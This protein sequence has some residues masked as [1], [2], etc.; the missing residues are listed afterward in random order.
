MFQHTHPL[1]PA[2]DFDAT[3]ILTTLSCEAPATES[4]PA[5][6]AVTT[7]SPSVLLDLQRFADKPAEVELL[8]VLAASVR[9]GTPLAL[10]LELDGRA[11]ELTL[12][13]RRQ[14]FY[15][16]VDLCTLAD[17]TLSRIRLLGVQPD[18]IVGTLFESKLLTGSLRPLLWH[19]ALRGAH[20]E[21]LPEI[22]GAVRCR[23]ALGI[24]LNGLPVDGA[25]KRLIQRMKAAPVSLDD[26]LTGSVLGR[27]AIQRI[28]NALYLQSAL[29]VSR[30]FSH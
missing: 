18:P 8:P 1:G 12:H 11:L 22:A 7:L 24:S 3:D 23:V 27:A 17:Q 4:S 28:W 19:L 20:A 10:S 25:T 30:A 21:L 2:S 29:M 15:C 5:G 16:A 26:L 9:Y 14:V 6:A 13:P